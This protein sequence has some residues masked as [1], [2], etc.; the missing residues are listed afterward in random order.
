MIRRL[1][2]LEAKGSFSGA[3]DERGKF[4]YLTA[5]EIERLVD[6]INQKGRLTKG[7]DIVEAVNRI[8]RLTPTADDLRKIEAEDREALKALEATLEPDQPEVC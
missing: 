2:D 4:V 1:R 3:L 8:V 7:E 5:Q 6:F